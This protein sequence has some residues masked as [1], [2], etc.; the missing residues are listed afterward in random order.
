MEAFQLSGN[1]YGFNN[2]RER[3]GGSMKIPRNRIFNGLIITGL[4]LIM[5]F[6][7][8]ATSIS[9]AEQDKQNLEEDLSEVEQII[10]GLEDKQGNAEEYLKELDVNLSAIS[11]ELAEMETNLTNK[12]SEL[13]KTKQELEEAKATEQKQ[14]EDMKKRIKFLYENGNSAY[15]EM[16][17]D[18]KDF[19]D[20]L[21]KA[22]Y[23]KQVSEY[24]RNMLIAYQETKQSIAEKELLTE[25]EYAQIETLQAKAEQQKASVEQLIQEKQKEMQEYKAQIKE[26]QELASSYEAEIEE[27]DALI[28]Q[29]EAAAAAERKRKE[30]AAKKAAAEAA[31]QKAAGQESTA[32]SEPETSV[33]ASGFV[34]PCPASRTISS[35]YGY[36]IHP[37]L[38]VNKLHNGIDISA[39]T[40]TVIVA[41]A[42]GTVVAASYSSSMGNYVMIDHGNDLY[43]IYMHCSG[44]ATSS[45]AVVQS[46][47]TIAY[48]GSTGQST[49]PHLHFSVRKDGS[50][51]NPWSYVSR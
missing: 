50:Y 46:G 25:Q 51:V 20:F 35:D 47:Q 40:G 43:T 18:A 48:V 22:D 19:A 8:S 10:K 37:I 38:G 45:G 27:Q 39:S 34:W 21:N 4:S 28:K 13:E 24:D 49:G 9:D 33:S 41:A 6:P 5:V 26:S 16:L 44:F 7:S 32:G 1:I 3:E 30:E 36:R 42:A 23:I 31:A 2:E 12:R 11:K 17:L 14:Y 29:L 15:L